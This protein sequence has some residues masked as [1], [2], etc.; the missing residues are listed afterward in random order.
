MANLNKRKLG[1][2]KKRKKLKKKAKVIASFVLFF[3]S[4]SLPKP[5]TKAKRERGEKKKKSNHHKQMRYKLNINIWLSFQLRSHHK[6]HTNTKSCRDHKG[7]RITTTTS[8]RVANLRVY[9][10]LLLFCVV[11]GPLN[12][13][14][15]PKRKEKEKE[16]FVQLQRAPNILQRGCLESAKRRKREQ[17]F[18]V[19]MGTYKVC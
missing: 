12:K 6:K 17:G 13:H 9:D 2:K 3:S 7:R 14:T 11:V 16:R 15:T 4:S 1:G 18:S 19:K 8:S 10:V 5:L